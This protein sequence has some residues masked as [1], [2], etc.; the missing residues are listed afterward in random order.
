MVSEKLQQLQNEIEQAMKEDIDNS[1]VGKLLE[2]YGL[3]DKLVKAQYIINLTRID[4]IAIKD[5][6]MKEALKTLPGQEIVIAS[7]C[8]CP[9]CCK[10]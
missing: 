1:K 8:F 10:C 5:Q 6:E 9:R 7:C 3:V 4:S 2:N